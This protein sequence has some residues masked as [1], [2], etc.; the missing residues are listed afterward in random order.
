MWRLAL[1][2][3]LD[4]QLVRRIGERVDETHRDRLDV[5][6]EQRID[7]A[8]RIRPIERTLDL[9]AMVDALVDGLAQITFHQRRGL[10]P[11]QIVEL[12]H[13]QRTALQHFTE[14]L[15]G[16]QPTRAPLCSRIAFEATVVPWRISS[17]AL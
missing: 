6:G 1:D 14:A 10:G 13:A 7:G 11:G 8:L 9:T 16:D 5:L 12:R 15:G 17:T 2:D 4:H 3:V